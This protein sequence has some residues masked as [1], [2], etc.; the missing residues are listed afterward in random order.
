MSC[1][2]K[3]TLLGIISLIEMSLSIFLCKFSTGQ[4]A[5]RALVNKANIFAY[6]DLSRIEKP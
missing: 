4:V 2:Y 3:Q 5:N 6:Y 1:E